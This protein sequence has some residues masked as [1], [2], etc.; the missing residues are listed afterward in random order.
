MRGHGHKACD[1]CLWEEGL[2]TV[3]VETLVVGDCRH[4]P[5][6]D[7]FVYSAWIMNGSQTGYRDV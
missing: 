1:D 6:E 4:Y 7:V 2:Q 5:L 3:L